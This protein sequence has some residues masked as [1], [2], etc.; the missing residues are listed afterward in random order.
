MTLVASGLED[1]P[2]VCSRSTPI[3]YGIRSNAPAS[4]YREFKNT[5]PD[6]RRF[7]R[8]NIQK[9]SCVFENVKVRYNRNDFQAVIDPLFETK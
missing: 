4:N 5:R 3:G 6:Q 2:C 8:P 7:L 9:G 1:E